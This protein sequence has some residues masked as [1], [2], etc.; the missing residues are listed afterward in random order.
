MK[1]K[2]AM[3]ATEDGNVDTRFGRCPKFKIVEIEGK[4]I[5]NEKTIENTA[6]TQAGG[7][8]IQSAQLLGNEKVEAVITGNLGPNAINTLKQLGIKSYQARGEIK[9]VMQ[10]F[11]D[12]KLKKIEE[13]T[14]P[15][16]G[17]IQK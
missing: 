4:E 8:G 5:K 3:S 14:G 11:L 2:I 15:L 10:Q 1:M 9:E 13:A 16:H 12:G 7:A 6:A 17:G